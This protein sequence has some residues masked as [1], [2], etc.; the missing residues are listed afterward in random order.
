MGSASEAAEK[1]SAHDRPT[2]GDPP[3]G[4]E[5]TS[6]WPFVAAAGAAGIYTGA[7]LFIIG[8]G[9]LALVPRYVGPIVFG[10]GIIVAL[11]GLFGWLYDAFVAEYWSDAL[12]GSDSD[13]HRLAMLL[14]VVTDI[15]TFAAGFV[16]YYFV[17]VSAWPPSNLPELLTSLVVVNT[18]VLVASSVTFEVAHRNLARGNRRTFVGF[19]FVTWL[20]GAGFVAGQAYEYYEQ[21]VVEG[22]TLSG[23]IFGSVFFGLTG[24]HGLHVVLGVILLGI[25]LVRAYAGQF[26]P[27]RDT[28]VETIGMYWHFVDAVWLV[29]VTSLYV[30]AS[31]G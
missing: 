20:L 4:I 17:R 7:G 23:G 24:L 2:G 16:Y 28:A 8:W 13:T 5:E 30:M 10:G 15:S 27:E 19:L 9:D 3:E 26:T 25:L 14:F 12:D 1:G 6:W 11:V 31:Y 18:V 21:I 22:F 29:I